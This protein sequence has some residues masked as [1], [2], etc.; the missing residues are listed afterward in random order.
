MEEEDTAA[1]DPAGSLTPKTAR[2]AARPA[3]KKRTDRASGRPSRR[4]APNPSLSAFPTKA[5]RRGSHRTTAQ[6][7]HT[8]ERMTQMGSPAYPGTIGKRPCLKS[9]VWSG[10]RDSNPRQPAWKAG[11]LPD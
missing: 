7:S 2:T 5:A 9:S 1:G 4:T 3:R 10:R 11:T 6:Y 8:D